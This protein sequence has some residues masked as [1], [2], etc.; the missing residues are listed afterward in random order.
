MLTVRVLASNPE[1]LTVV[2]SVPAS[3]T[4]WPP[5]D[6]PTPDGLIGLLSVELLQPAMNPST[7]S[8][9]ARRVPV[10]RAVEKCIIKASI[11]RVANLDSASRVLPM[12]SQEIA[13][14]L[15]FCVPSELNSAPQMT[16]VSKCASGWVHAG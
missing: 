11:K 5:T 8:T 3:C 7:Q 15:G 12:L 2:A 6:E 16:I 14:L 9:L 1:K 13:E 4:A 10:T